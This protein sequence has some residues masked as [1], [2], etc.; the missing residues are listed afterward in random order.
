[1]PTRKAGAIAASGTTPFSAGTGAIEVLGF[2]QQQQN[3]HY[4]GNI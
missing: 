1:M 2:P 4:R 3:R